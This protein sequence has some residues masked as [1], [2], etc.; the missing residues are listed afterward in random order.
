MLSKEENELLT[1]TGPGTPMGDLFRRFWLPVMLAEEVPAPDCPAVR[2]RILGEDLLGFR[3]SDGRVGIIDP[4]CAHRG[5][6]L[7]FG[8]NEERGLRCV[9]HGWKYD[10][11]GNCIDIPN[12]AEGASYKKKV[13]LFSYPVAEK[14]GFIWAY[15]GPHEKQPPLPKFEWMDLPRSYYVVSKIV[16]NCNYFQ[17]LE[18]SMDPTHG[19]FLHSTPDAAANPMGRLGLFDTDN[20]HRDRMARYLRVD[21]TAYGVVGVVERNAPN[22]RRQ[23][24]INHWVAPTFTPQAR[25]S[26]SLDLGYMRVRVPIDDENSCVFRIRYDPR[27][28]LP[29]R[30]RH[31]YNDGDFLTPELIPGTYWPV[32]NKEND[33][34][35]DRF[36]QRNFTFTG[37]KSFP[38]QDIAV[39]ENQWGP[40]ADRTREHLVASDEMII[41]VRRHLLKMARDLGEG[42][43]P[44]APHRPE[45]FATQ[46]I[47]MRLPKDAPV[48]EAITPHLVAAGVGEIGR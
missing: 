29:D 47:T 40:I 25:G 46:P 30:I 5:A 42:I 21:D 2:L 37:I 48:E 6:P 13:K 23:V 18:G 31:E 16:S 4:Y 28:P 14:A 36:M 10:V 33:Y 32:A 17:S 15:M 35:I 41:R 34:F 24:S 43:E 44:P 12:I 8:R 20:S 11:E 26:G 9:Y 3:D 27:Q 1:R 19:S 7:F 39:I 38:L 45:L 22:D